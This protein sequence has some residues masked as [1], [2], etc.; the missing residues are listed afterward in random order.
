MTDGAGGA[1]GI[2]LL[3]GAVLLLASGVGLRLHRVEAAP[4]RLI[5]RVVRPHRAGRLPVSRQ[6]RCP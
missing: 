2:P 4:P 5:R 6:I 3:G 1:A